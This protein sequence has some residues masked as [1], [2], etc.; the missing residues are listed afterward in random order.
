[1]VTTPIAQ[2]TNPAA[3]PPRV[4][5]TQLTWDKERRQLTAESST[6]FGS[7]QAQL[8]KYAE[9]NGVP[10]TFDIHSPKTDR[11]YR[12]RLVQTEKDAD[13]DTTSWRYRPIARACPVLNVVVY[14]D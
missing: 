12:F 13:G 6:L 14:N 5:L 10:R 2:G 1:M 8:T 9:T 4:E 3:I 7:L 11:T